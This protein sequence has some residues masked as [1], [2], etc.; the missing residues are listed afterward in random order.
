MEGSVVTTQPAFDLDER[1]TFEFTKTLTADDVEAF[2]RVSG[3]NQPLHLDDA[4]AAKS[5]FKKRIAHGILTAG[6]ISAAI[7]TQVAPGQVVIYMGQTL[8]FLA[9]VYLGDTVTAKLSVISTNAP[10]RQATLLATVTNQDGAEVL[11]GESRV[12]V[13]PYED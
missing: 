7:G 11:K 9:P 4:M 2:A 1:K 3:D 12:M 6:I 8:N 10:R 13:E 5:R